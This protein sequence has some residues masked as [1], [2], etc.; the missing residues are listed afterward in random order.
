MQSS[1]WSR[2]TTK[3]VALHVGQLVGQHACVFVAGPAQPTSRWGRARPG[4][5]TTPTVKGET[6]RVGIANT[7]RAFLMLSL[8]SNSWQSSSQRAGMRSAPWC[9]KRCRKRQLP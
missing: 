9:F 7:V 3:I 2:L 5:Q 6:G 1:D 4:A 8:A